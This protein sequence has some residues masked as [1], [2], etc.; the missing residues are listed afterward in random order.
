MYR[1][2]TLHYDASNEAV[3]VTFTQVDYEGRE[4]SVENRSKTFRKYERNMSISEN[5]MAAVVWCSRIATLSH[6]R[7]HFKIITDHNALLYLLS[8]KE[9]LGKLARWVMYLSQF[10]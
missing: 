6:Y 4:Y 5:E 3:G 9:P 1:A 7:R 2:L 8:L 10:D